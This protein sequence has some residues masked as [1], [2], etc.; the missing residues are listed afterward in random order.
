MNGLRCESL[1]VHHVTLKCHGFLPSSNAQPVTVHTMYPIRPVPN[2]MKAV[3]RALQ[4][5]QRAVDA[6][7]DI[8]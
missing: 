4:L 5:A 1:A 8:I 2:M 6:L 3:V 7:K